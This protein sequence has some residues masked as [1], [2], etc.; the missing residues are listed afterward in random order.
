MCSAADRARLDSFLNR[1][2]QHGFCDKDLPSVTEL[3][4]DA[5]DAFFVRI[6]TNSQHVLQRQRYLPDRPVHIGV[7]PAGDAGDVSPPIFWLVGTS[8]GMSPPIFGVVM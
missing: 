4:S 6:N 7:N 8:M 2:K 5:D 3:F 1:C